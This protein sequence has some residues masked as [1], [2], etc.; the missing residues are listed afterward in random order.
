MSV[1]S[2]IRPPDPENQ[3]PEEAPAGEI[4]DGYTL[5]DRATSQCRTARSKVSRST[6]RPQMEKTIMDNRVL[7]NLDTCVLFQI[8]IPILSFRR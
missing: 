4:N 5:P 7:M 2:D 1:M 6:R 8:G 3:T